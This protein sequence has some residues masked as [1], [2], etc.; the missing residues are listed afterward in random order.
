MFVIYG[1]SI[2]RLPFDRAY[3]FSER[4][5]AIAIT[6]TL[7]IVL[8]NITTDSG[9]LAAIAGEMEAEKY[10]EVFGSESFKERMED[11]KELIFARIERYFIR[12]DEY[13][14]FDEV[15]QKAL[16]N[17]IFCVPGLSCSVSI[18]KCSRFKRPQE[19]SIIDLVNEELKIITTFFNNNG[20][21][22]LLKADESISYIMHKMKTHSRA[23]F[24]DFTRERNERN[25]LSSKVMRKLFKTYPKLEGL[26]YQYQVD[27]YFKQLKKK[28]HPDVGGNE[29]ICSTINNDHAEIKTSIWYISMDKYD[30]ATALK[31]GANRKGKTPKK[32]KPK[33]PP[34]KLNESNKEGNKDD[35]QRKAT[36]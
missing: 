36:T 26:K 25:R 15:E 17:E 11:F 27:W 21:N 30:E 28:Y 24:E 3:A 23:S 22:Y 34:A 13:I 6:P 9:E 16:S 18:V 5:I 35:G 31:K 29:F 12:K 4:D 2:M 20:I 7:S 1:S 33:G 8:N 32:E 14:F 10:K 19:V